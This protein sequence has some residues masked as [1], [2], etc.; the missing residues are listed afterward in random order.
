MNKG[1]QKERTKRNYVQEESMLKPL[2]KRRRERERERESWKKEGG[3]QR[4]RLARRY[5]GA[6]HG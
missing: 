2:I 4:K 6:N 5:N 1:R 3:K